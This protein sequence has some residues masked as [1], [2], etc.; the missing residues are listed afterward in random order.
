MLKK[1]FIL[2]SLIAVFASYSYSQNQKYLYSG[3][4][5]FF[6]PG[7]TIAENPH[8][9]IE[10][11][12][13]GIG[14]MLRF[15]IKDHLT[16]GIIGGNQK[17]GYDTEFSKNSNISLGY[18]GPFVGYTYLKNKFRF[19]ASISVAKGKIKNLHVS[20]QRGT[21]ITE[22]YYY[23]YSATIAYPMISFDYLMTSKI[24]FTGQAIFL[25]AKYNQNDLYFCPV[26]QIGILFNR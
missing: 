15:Y 16:L 5:L 22:A 8:Q 17:T 1:L 26:F 13:F 24:A 10:S 23:K 19:C 12:G 25:T 2:I 11:L 20:Q 6:Q 9:T 14:G 4:M 7:F 3:G 21:A 18:G